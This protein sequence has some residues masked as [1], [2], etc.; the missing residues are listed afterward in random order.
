MCFQVLV[1]VASNGTPTCDFMRVSCSLRLIQQAATLLCRDAALQQKGPLKR[2]GVKAGV[3]GFEPRQSAPEALVLPLHHTPKS[4]GA[5]R[6]GRGAIQVHGFYY[7]HSAFASR[8]WSVAGAEQRSRQPGPNA[9][10]GLP[11]YVLLVNL[12][13]A[14]RIAVAVVVRN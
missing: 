3:L 5:T 8:V 4:S 2:A 11:G 14:M 10:W 13:F 7:R 1:L 6:C 9:L 12:I